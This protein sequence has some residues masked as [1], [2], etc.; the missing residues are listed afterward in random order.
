[1]RDNFGQKRPVIVL[2]N[3]VRHAE[4]PSYRSELPVF[5]PDSDPI[6]WQKFVFGIFRIKEVHN[7]LSG[8]QLQ[9]NDVTF[10]TPNREEQ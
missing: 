9:S 4:A 2:H 3:Q 7:A 1:M 10:G 8:F 6:A 5:L